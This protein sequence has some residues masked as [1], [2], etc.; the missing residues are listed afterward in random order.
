MLIYIKYSLFNFFVK[1]RFLIFVCVRFII[2][3]IRSQEIEIADIVKSRIIR[4]ERCGAISNT[5]IQKIFEL[6]IIFPL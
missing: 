4:L 5:K 3:K 2:E 1:R 6:L